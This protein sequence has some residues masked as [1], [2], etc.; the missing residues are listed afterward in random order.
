[1]AIRQACHAGT[2][3][4]GF[5]TVHR[6][7]VHWVGILHHLISGLTWQHMTIPKQRWARV[8][9]QLAT[10]VWQEGGARVLVKLHQRSSSPS[11][12]VARALCDE[13]RDQELLRLLGI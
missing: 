5:R 1:M 4:R 13:F 8:E 6:G 2:P 3:A 11:H 7:T 10:C 12:T 9:V